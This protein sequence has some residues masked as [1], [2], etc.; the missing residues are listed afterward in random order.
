LIGFDKKENPKV[1]PLGNSRKKESEI[2]RRIELFFWG[3]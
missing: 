2:I 1:Y 3:S